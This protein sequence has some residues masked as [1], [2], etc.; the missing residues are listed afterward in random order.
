MILTLYFEHRQESHIR[1]LRSRWNPVKTQP[2]S[3]RNPASHLG[4]SK[5]HQE[6]GILFDKKNVCGNVAKNNFAQGLICKMCQIFIIFNTNGP[7]M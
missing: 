3:R 7:K 6:S 2:K 1:I 4:L 5:N